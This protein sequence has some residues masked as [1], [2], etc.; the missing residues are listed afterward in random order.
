MVIVGGSMSLNGVSMVVIITYVCRFAI[1]MTK[2]VSFEDV[3]LRRCDMMY[4][5][6]RVGMSVGSAVPYCDMMLLVDER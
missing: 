5:P 3:F 1:D 4:E 6:S 2:L